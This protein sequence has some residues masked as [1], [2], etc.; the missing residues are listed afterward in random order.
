MAR[1]SGATP[2]SYF[3][4]NQGLITTTLATRF[5]LRPFD[6][7]GGTPISITEAS[8]LGIPQAGAVVRVTGNFTASL[9]ME[10]FFNGSWQPVLDL[11]DSLQTVQGTSVITSLSGG[12][13]YTPPP[14]PTATPTA[15]AT[16]TATPTATP[17]ATATDTATPTSTSTTI[18]TATPTNTAPPTPTPE[19]RR[20]SVYLPVI[21]R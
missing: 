16:D 17:T 13:F 3:D 1:W 18:P 5:T 9:L 7:S 12:F 11:F 4:P 6:L 8:T 2:I 21:Q 14:E 20:Y 19:K 15:T 10:A